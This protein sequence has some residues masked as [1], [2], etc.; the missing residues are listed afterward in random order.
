[1]QE[2]E[3]RMFDMQDKFRTEEQTQRVELLHKF[4]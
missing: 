3:L 2:Q 4:I 1:M